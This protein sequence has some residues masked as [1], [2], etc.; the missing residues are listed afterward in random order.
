MQKDAQTA[1]VKNVFHNAETGAFEAQVVLIDG[2][3][4]HAYDVA[5][6]APITTE[7][8]AL[9]PALIAAAEAQHADGTS[10]LIRRTTEI[11]RPNR[12]AEMLERIF[13]AQPNYLDD[14]LRRAA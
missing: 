12:T 7:F 8:D 13:A 5:V 11:V 14:I 2:R 6:Q 4:Q 1:N 3:V 9:R 10:T